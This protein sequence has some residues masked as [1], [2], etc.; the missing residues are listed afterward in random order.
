MNKYYIA[1][2]LRFILIAGNFHWNVEDV[3]KSIVCMIMSGPCL[4]GY[5]QVYFWSWIYFVFP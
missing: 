3:A 5:T 2:C 1:S 4:T